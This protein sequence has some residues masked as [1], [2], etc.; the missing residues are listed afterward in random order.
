MINALTLSYDIGG[1]FL[2][3]E[4]II[5]RRHKVDIVNSLM[6]KVFEAS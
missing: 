4:V 5:V 3:R 6:Q 2:L 1:Y